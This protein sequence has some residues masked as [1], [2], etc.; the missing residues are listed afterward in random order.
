[1]KRI[2]TLLLCFLSFFCNAQLAEPVVVTT[3]SVT[4]PGALAVATWKNEHKGQQ[5]PDYP[6]LYYGFSAGDEISIDFS[7]ENKKGTNQIE[8]SEYESKSV[9]Y[10]N[11]E[12]QT[13]DGIKIKVP[14][15]AVY[16]FEFATNHMFDRSCKIV[17]KRVPSTDVTKNF[18]CN[19]IWQTVND[20]TFT[21]EEQKTKMSS[22]YETV[23]LQSPI[24]Q[25]LNGGLNSAFVDGKS[26]TTFPI[27]LPENTV[28]WYY[29]FAATRNK[30]SVEATRSEMHLLANLT[31]LI[32][33]SGMLAFGVEAISTPPGSDYC[34]VF[35]M[36]SKYKI[37]FENKSD[38][39]WTPVPEG[40]RENLMSGT[41]RMRNCCKN[42]TYLIGFRNPSHSFGIDV[43]I[44]VV[45]V[46][47]K[48]TYETHQVKK[49]LSIVT[50][51]VP[52][53]GN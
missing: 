18:N 23:S 10:S 16:K 47:E 33:A 30:Q 25:H 11:K 34:D 52:V 51:K 27:T 48:A 22:T 37:Y 29:T 45:A 8:I 2:L 3:Q 7:M 38:N 50:K 6:K 17:I 12:F 40:S 9:V 31:K 19:V 35:I 4:I 49:P 24:G 32:D 21:T 15:T 42:G 14:K 44:E 28:E 20:T 13:L 36:D 46:V 41:V 1:M 39:A 26:R 53:F 5:Y 43:L